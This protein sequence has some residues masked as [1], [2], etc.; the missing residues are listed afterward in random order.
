[1]PKSPVVRQM[2]LNHV[3]HT[4]EILIILKKSARIM[5]FV[6]KAIKDIIR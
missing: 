4:A 1:M 3:S 6:F 5:K 2:V